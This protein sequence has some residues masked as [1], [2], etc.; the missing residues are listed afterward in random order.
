[1]EERGTA[2]KLGKVANQSKP[3]SLSKPDDSKHPNTEA[4]QSKAFAFFWL[5][6]VVFYS[7]QSV[8]DGFAMLSTHF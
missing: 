8:F 5:I 4:L 7:N 6:S 2:L 1:M 3:E